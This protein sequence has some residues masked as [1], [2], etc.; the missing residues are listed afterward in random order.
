[1]YFFF[2]GRLRLSFVLELKLRVTPLAMISSKR[3]CSEW[4]FGKSQFFVSRSSLFSARMYSY[5]RSM[6]LRLRGMCY[7]K[8]TAHIYDFIEVRQFLPPQHNG[9]LSVYLKTCININ[10]NETPECFQKEISCSPL[11]KEIV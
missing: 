6:C 11:F 1:M 8:N 4:I 7:D 2:N 3:C 5:T 10:L 9:S